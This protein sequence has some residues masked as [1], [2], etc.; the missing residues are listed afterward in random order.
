MAGIRSK[1]LKSGKFQGWYKDTNGRRA[2]FLGTHDKRETLRMAQR[3]EDDHHQVA[4]GYRQPAKPWE[5]VAARDIDDAIAEYLAWGK[6][7]GGIDGHPWGA[8]HQRKRAGYL[9][10]WKTKLKLEIL[11]DLN[12]VLSAAELVLRDLRKDDGAKPSGKTLENYA[13]GLRAFCAW[14]VT[15]EQLGANP[16]AGMAEHNITPATQRRAFALQ[17]IRQ[18]FAWIE[19]AGH[20]RAKRR[21][22]GYQMAVCTGLR[23]NELHRLRRK[24]FD[25]DRG[26]LILEPEWTKNRKEGMQPLP[27]ALVATLAEVSKDLDAETPLV[28]IAT[29]R[30]KALESDLINAGLA[31][32]GPGGQGDFHS[33]RGSFATLL[34]QSGASDKEQQILLRHAAHSITQERYTKTFEARL[35]ELVEIIGKKVLG[36]CAAGVLRKAVGAESQ[37]ASAEAPS[38]YADEKKYPQGD[39]NPGR[40]ALRGLPTALGSATV[41]PLNARAET[42]LAQFDEV[43]SSSVQPSSRHP[44]AVPP[45]EKCVPGVMRSLERHPELA[46]LVERW[47]FLSAHIQQTILTL[48]EASTPKEHS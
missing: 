37:S 16:L 45:L 12:S 3:L 47:A 42:G 30:A 5:A 11:D 24:H 6:A 35:V 43:K 1:A 44:S 4:L 18:L 10:F 15:R 39:L 8:D 29:D 27:A 31:R 34:D 19:T 28:Y 9:K 21:L 46:S 38:A 2:W 23:A 36:D 48:V 7:Q 17:E 14:L 25:A 13:D 33:F 40:G 26:R 32:N 41:T 22:L 20:K